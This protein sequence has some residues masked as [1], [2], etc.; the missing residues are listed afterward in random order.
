MKRQTI[1]TEKEYKEALARIEELFNILPGD[2]KE[3]EF[4]LIC[5]LVE[6]YED[7]NYKIDP[8]DPIEAIKFRKEQMGGFNIEMSN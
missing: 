6:K 4:D 1:K 3:E 7:E 2:P 5:R 8:P